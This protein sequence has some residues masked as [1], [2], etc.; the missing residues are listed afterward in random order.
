MKK[1]ELTYQDDVGGV[2]ELQLVGDEDD[3]LLGQQIHQAFL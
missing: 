2:Q 3:G 1:Q